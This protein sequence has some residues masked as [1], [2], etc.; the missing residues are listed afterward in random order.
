MS[1]SPSRVLSEEPSERRHRVYQSCRLSSSGSLPKQTTP[2]RQFAEGEWQINILATDGA[3]S[4]NNT[5]AGVLRSASD[6]WDANDFSEPPPAPS[7]SLV[8]S[9]NHA[10]WKNNPGRYAGD[11]RSIHHDGNY[12]D[13]DVASAKAEATTSCNLFEW[14][15]FPP[16]SK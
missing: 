10:D 9:F 6:T 4:D 2:D 14:A 12:W 7:G 16:G 13:F 3:A 1:W 15:I 8:L 5:A 11:F